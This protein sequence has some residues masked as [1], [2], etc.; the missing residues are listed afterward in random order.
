MSDLRSPWH[1]DKRARLSPQKTAKLFL[2]RH[3]CC[4]D[5]GRKLGPSDDWIVEHIIALENGGSNDWDNLGITCSWCVP[6][7]NAADHGEA[8]KS[9]KAATRHV[10][11]KSMKRSKFAGSRNSKWKKKL[12]GQVVER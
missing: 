9:R 8:A 10:L 3:G 1:H 5:C 12:N 7:K 4:R 11:P 6:A 2:E